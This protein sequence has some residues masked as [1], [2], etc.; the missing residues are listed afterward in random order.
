MAAEIAPTILSESIDDFQ[1]KIRRYEPF[2]KRAHIDIADGE[3]APTVTV[4]VGQLYWPAEWRVDIHVMAKR[5]SEYIQSLIDLHP[6]S[7]IL[8]AEADEDLT[9]LFDQ[10]KKAEIRIGIA[11]LRST[12]PKTVANYIEAADHVMIFSGD[13]GKYGGSAHMIQL[14]KVRLIHKIN[15]RVEIGWDGGA[16]PDNVFT[17]AQGGVD[18]INSGGAFDSAD[19]PAEL[20]ERMVAEANKKGM[21]A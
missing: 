12:V 1:Q 15:A 19:N 20:Y 11:L 2:A 9:P 10:L 7:V 8:H 4:S 13:L 6:Y 18:V 21:F 14:E 5:P 16:T 17:L 3:F